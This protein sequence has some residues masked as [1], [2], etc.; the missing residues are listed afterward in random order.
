MKFKYIIPAITLLSLAGCAAKNIVETKGDKGDLVEVF[1]LD[2]KKFDKFITKK[3]STK[4]E[5]SDDLVESPL[6]KK[7][8]KKKKVVTKKK[9]VV[10]AK[11]AKKPV[12]KAE[13][14]KKVVEPIIEPVKVV[15]PQTNEDYPKSYLDYNK[16]KKY[17]DSYRPIT[18][19]GE[20]IS[21]EVSWTL[22]KAGV[23]TIETIG[24]L[25]IGG[26]DVIGYRASIESADYFENIYKLKDVLDTYISKDT[27]LPVKYVLKQRESGQSVDDLQLFD[28]DSLKTYFWYNRIKKGKTKKTEKEAYTPKYFMDSFSAIQFIRGLPLKVGKKFE[29]P[30]ITRTKVWLFSAVVEKTEKIDFLGKKVKAYKVK[31]ETKYPGVLK[32]KGDINFW[33]TADERRI[34]LRLE[35]KI[36]IGSVKATIIDYK[37]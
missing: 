22:F 20:K 32:K 13:V 31:A 37:N 19:P 26:R 36:K 23:A 24:D 28:H 12:Q 11:V 35:A 33:L 18:K 17:W 9:K 27:H 6:K 5:V 29:F 34:P 2:D 14:E 30:V 21:L 15:D 4:K 25:E 1:N 16:Y 3:K 8:K 7:P 10:K